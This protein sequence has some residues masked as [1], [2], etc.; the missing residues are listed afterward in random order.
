MNFSWQMQQTLDAVIFD[1]DGTLSQLEGIDELAVQNGVGEVVQSLT[2]EA[3]ISSG[4]TPD[5]YEKRLNLVKPRQ[6]Q[7]EALGNAYFEQCSPDVECV[8]NILQKLGKTVFIMSAGLKPAVTIF[9]ESL[10]IAASCVYAV[11]VKFDNHGNYIG[12][13]PH[14]LL[15]AAQGKSKLVQQIKLH[16]PTLMHV[17]DGMNDVDTKAFVDRFVGYG[18]IFSR[19]S[20]RAH[21][22]FYIQSASLAPILA[23]ALTQKEVENLL[24]PD[25]SVYAK[26]LA[27][28]KGSKVM[29]AERENHG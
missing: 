3:M 22:D 2:S 5:L 14:S 28:I 4:M 23:L 15:T 17:G 19:P 21:S 7:V 8:V 9:A 27:L 12:F 16:Y 10:G 11:E 24:E 29:F 18:G 20:I 25:Y 1:C 13:N 6:D 26:G